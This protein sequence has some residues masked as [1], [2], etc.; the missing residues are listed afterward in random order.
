MKHPAILLLPVL[1]FLDYF[2]TVLGAVQRERK[3]AEHFKVEHYELNPLWQKAIS[4]K[5][6]VNPRHIV[7]TLLVSGLLALMFQFELL[8]DAFAEGTM[9]FLF[10]I[11]G[12]VIGRHLSNILTFRG[13]ARRAKEVSGQVT[14]SHSLTLAVSTYQYLTVAVPVVIIAFF[15]PSPFTV[16]GA[17]GIGMLFVVHGLWIRRHN[18]ARAKTDSQA[19]PKPA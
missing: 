16:G 11:F 10:V 17:F 3:H 15:S 4:R 8:P 19:T 6:L 14:L 9:G 1:M 13:Y 18:K 2:L 5:R 7:L 12:T